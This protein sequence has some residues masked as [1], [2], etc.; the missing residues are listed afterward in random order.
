MLQTVEYCPQRGFGEKA[1]IMAGCDHAVNQDKTNT[2]PA[3]DDEEDDNAPLSISCASLKASP[4][5]VIQKIPTSPLR[6]LRKQNSIIA[7]QNSRM[8]RSLRSGEAA[9]MS[10]SG[11]VLRSSRRS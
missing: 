4:T 5:A 10:T 7:G 8:L 3:D 6:Q 11:R 1:A 2:V 9:L